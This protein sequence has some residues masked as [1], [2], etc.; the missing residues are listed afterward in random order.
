MFGYGTSKNWS[1]R[2]P[3]LIVTLSAKFHWF[4][5]FI[6]LY[7]LL[8]CFMYPMRNNICFLVLFICQLKT[9]MS[10][11]TLTIPSCSPLSVLQARHSPDY[12]LVITSRSQL[13][14]QIEIYISQDRMLL[15]FTRLSL[16]S[17]QINSVLCGNTLEF[18]CSYLSTNKIWNWIL[19]L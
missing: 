19:I 1:I 18:K 15:M 5:L 9:A 16:L 7:I 13:S 2:V 11:S 4:F 10:T 12:S 3:S 17:F 8:T 6:M 14:R